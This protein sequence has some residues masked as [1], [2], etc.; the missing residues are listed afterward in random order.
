MRSVLIL[1]F[2]YFLPIYGF[3]QFS[4]KNVKLTWTEKGAHVGNDPSST[5]K[6]L[7]FDGAVNDPSSGNLPLYIHRVPWESN[8]DARIEIRNKNF[9]P[10]IENDLIPADAK[11]SKSIRI[12]H[13]IRKE[14]QNKYLIIEV[15]PIRQSANGSFE[16]LES[17]TLH[18]EATNAP[19]RSA[20]R[21]SIDFKSNSVLANGE[22]HKIAVRQSGIFKIDRA[23]LEEKLGWDMNSVNPKNIRIYGNGG[24]TL[25]EPLNIPFK[26]DLEEIAI[27]VSGEDDGSFDPGDY[28]LFY[29]DG[30]TQILID[31]SNPSLSLYHQQNI[32]DSLTYYF[33]T[34]D[35]GPGKRITQQSG[36]S[37]ANYQST[38]YDLYL[39]HEVDLD[40]LTNS[41]RQ[42]HGETFDLLSR[43]RHFEFDL[44]ELIP[45]TE[46]NINAG[47]ASRSLVGNTAFS[48]E[49]N[50][51]LLGSI[52]LKRVLPEYWQTYA[53]GGNISKSIL[54]NPGPLDIAI[55]YQPNAGDANSQGWL[56]FIAVRARKK[57]EAVKDQDFFMDL[58]SVSPGRI[59]TFEIKGPSDLSI[60]DVSDHQNVR[61]QISEYQNG[62]HRF[63]LSSEI[64]RKFI[65]FTGR[66]YFTPKYIGPVANQNLH[67]TLGTPEFLIVS[68]GPFMDE[69]RRL[70]DFHREHDQMDVKV[71]NIEKVYNE[72]ASGAQ[73]I[74][75]IRNMAK[76]IYDREVNGQKPFR[77]LLLFGDASFDYKNLEVPTGSNTNF[78]P[79]YESYESLNRSSTFSSDDYFGLLDDDEGQNIVS[80]GQLMDIGIGRIPADNPEEAHAAVSKIIHYH[81]AASYGSWRN[82]TTFIADDQDN[83]LHLN[84]SEKLSDTFHLYNPA[85]NI[86]KIYLD[87]Y[88]QVSTPGG[89]RYPE[90]EDAI[91]SKIYSGTLFMNY[92]GH[93]GEGGLAHERIM[94][95]DMIRSWK[96][97][98][99][100]ML[101]I[102]ATCSFAR[103]DNP[104]TET[105]GELVLFNANGG[106]VALISTV[107]LVYASANYQLNHALIKEL[108]N[109]Q[110]GTLPKLG[111]VIRKT[112]NRIDTKANNRKFALLGDPAMRLGYPQL[113]IRSTAIDK[114]P[115]VSLGDT[116]SAL[117][118]VTISGEI[119]NTD[120]TPAS[121]F[122]GIVYPSLFDK[123]ISIKTLQNDADSR[124]KTFNVE[125]NILYKGKASVTGGKFEYTFIVPKDINYDFGPG[126]LSYYAN[127]GT[128]DGQGYDYTIVGGSADS[129]AEDNSG[130]EVK[131]YMNDE[132]FISGGMTD[133]NP[134]LLVRLAD[135]NGINTAGNAIGHNITGVLDEENENPL[136]LNEFYESELDDFTQGEARYPL[137]NLEPGLHKIKVTA[138][139]VYN[140]SG[141]GYTEFIVA[142]NAKLALAHVLNYPNPFTTNTEFW[143]E[144]NKPGQNLSLKIE[145]FTISGRLI[146]TI[147]QEI[148]SEGYQVRGIRWDGKDEFGDDIG[149]GIY[150]YHLQL[151]SEDG[152]EA[153]EFA[154]M[155]LL[156]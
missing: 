56:D 94:T 143:F 31:S 48:L 47:L 37:G 6:V 65:A 38:G 60:W 85:Y 130:P 136:I 155:V 50:G 57:A 126:K 87:A 51:Q 76:M 111:D 149:K 90:V 29:G 142:E 107:R 137:S 54:I 131:V 15:L 128:L 120:G 33:I 135:E 125:K 53:S 119:L 43:E 134:V 17:F 114:K 11:L 123:E 154:K 152:D 46:V 55:K 80:G 52:S 45:G 115:F 74:T 97:Y 91:N 88:P 105:A 102:T 89:A 30:P 98:D 121:N 144:H 75:A 73:D 138:W 49:A 99:R 129:F 64:L 22:W 110:N 93:G 69:A 59:S 42:F 10:L 96:N 139:D 18:I 27:E 39:Y 95:H 147:R 103:Y 25:P 24:G 112:K 150:I 35:L 141:E 133:A 19:K 79:T 61:Q 13:F 36:I 92:T 132:N 1:L 127:Q 109:F 41:G 140:N 84:Q 151:R 34:K 72:F 23:F 116:L 108:F 4:E 8:R 113:R 122:N 20:M 3:S 77:Y 104:N 44:S 5:Q 58:E 124:S 21:R 62:R 78:I 68:Y 118:K 82:S 146:K 16:K 63:S 100:L 32:Y 145:I 117:E 28:I 66:Q 101:L 156:K 40:N 153:R 26:D 81:E 83:N 2:L 14:R 106:A 148:N 71:V 9:V 70:A 7:Y 67:G 12:Q 86:D